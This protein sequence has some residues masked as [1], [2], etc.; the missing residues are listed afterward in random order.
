MHT[1]AGPGAIPAIVAAKGD[2]HEEIVAAG[3]LR[4]GNRPSMLAMLSGAA[5]IEV[6]GQAIRVG[7]AS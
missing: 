5:L 6:D 3:E 4:Q 7:R 1:I 2:I